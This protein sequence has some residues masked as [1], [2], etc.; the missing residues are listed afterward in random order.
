MK[1]TI[2]RYMY[3]LIKLAQL[4]ALRE[5]LLKE[6]NRAL[7][8]PEELQEL[9]RIIT[10][11]ENRIQSYENAPTNNGKANKNGNGKQ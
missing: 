4:M 5:V 11:T 2:Q 1:Y 10:L 3:D 9:D 8:L 6:H 7:W